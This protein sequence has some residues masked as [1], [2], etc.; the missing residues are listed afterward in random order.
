MLN[1]EFIKVETVLRTASP[2]VSNSSINFNSDPNQ[3][4]TVKQNC[5]YEI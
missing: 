2:S 3:M 1:F 4:T 5:Q